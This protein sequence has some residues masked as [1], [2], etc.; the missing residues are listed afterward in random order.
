MI[1]KM[2]GAALVALLFTGPMAFEAFA[3]SSGGT[4][5]E[6]TAPAKPKPPVKAHAAAKAKP[7]AMPEESASTAGLD[8]PPCSRAVK[9]HCIQ[10][11]QRNLAKAYPQCSSVKGA[12]RRAA[13]IEDAYKQTKS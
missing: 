13:C 12:D 11:W 4:T 2:I 6:T 10:L 3:Q 9:D 8:Y 1:S 7:K 5:S